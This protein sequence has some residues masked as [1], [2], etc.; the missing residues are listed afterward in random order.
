[1]MMPVHLS[2]MFVLFLLIAYISQFSISRDVA[3][4]VAV[5]GT[6]DR[7]EGH[8]DV[9]KSCDLGRIGTSRIEIH[10]TLMVATLRRNNDYNDNAY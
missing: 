5:V 3:G 4:T 6:V 7:T 9:G 8:V 2:G 10:R 1:M